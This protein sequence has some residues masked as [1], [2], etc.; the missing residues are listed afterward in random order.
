MG[1]V[2]QPWLVWPAMVA[3]T[4]LVFL[5]LVSPGGDGGRYGWAV[6]AVFPVLL[7]VLTVFLIVVGIAALKRRA[8]A[9]AR[10]PARPTVEASGPE[11][12]R[13]RDRRFG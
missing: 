13:A 10:P 4:L 9:S 11:D 5:K 2:S 1:L 6:G 8:Q 12:P 3:W 7:L